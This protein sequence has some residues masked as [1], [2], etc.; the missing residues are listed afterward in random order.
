MLA[1]GGASSGGAYP[2]GEQRPKR[3]YPLRAHPLRH[4]ARVQ[5][6]STPGTYPD[7]EQRPKCGYPLGAHPLGGA[8]VPAST[9]TPS[10]STADDGNTKRHRDWHPDNEHHN[11][12]LHEDDEFTRFIPAIIPLL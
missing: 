8:C 4:L 11:R 9:P 7:S 10:P 5:G 3:G 1:H 2:D 6:G 12:L